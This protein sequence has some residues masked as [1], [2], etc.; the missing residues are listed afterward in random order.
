MSETKSVPD[1]LPCPF[2]GDTDIVFSGSAMGSYF[3]CRGCMAEG[4]V[5]DADDW[6]K[7]KQAWNR[8]AAPAAP[9]VAELQRRVAELEKALSKTNGEADEYWS[10][11]S[12][13]AKYFGCKE[14]VD[15]RDFIVKEMDK[16]KADAVRGQALART[17]MA[18]Q[19]GK[20]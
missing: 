9:S 2:C 4:S 13:L 16:L 19:V 11:I 7:A 18:D 10:F 15:M 5:V 12:A 20:A 8:R 6:D 1:L 17:V 3:H 14:G